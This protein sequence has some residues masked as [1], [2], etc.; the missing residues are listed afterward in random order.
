MLGTNDQLNVPMLYKRSNYP[1]GLELLTTNPPDP[2]RLTVE[3]N[4]QPDLAVGIPIFVG[5]RKKW[6][7]LC[8][9]QCGSNTNPLEIQHVSHFEI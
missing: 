8:H 9:P 7:L 3:M 6:T 1:K 4:H 5:W 2:H